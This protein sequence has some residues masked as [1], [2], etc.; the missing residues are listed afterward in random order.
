ME[1]CWLTCPSPR[2][3]SRQNI[4]I[5]DCCLG[6]FWNPDALRSS[7]LR[8][9]R[10]YLWRIF[11]YENVRVDDLTH[12]LSIYWVWRLH[13]SLAQSRIS[14]KFSSE[15]W[16]WLQ[17]KLHMCLKTTGLKFCFRRKPYGYDLKFYQ[18]DGSV[19]RLPPCLIW[20]WAMTSTPS[21]STTSEGPSASPGSVQGG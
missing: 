5:R 15:W 20:P 17:I 4:C 13:V 2:S 14:A 7:V 11:R 19:C 21:T 3:N 8:S 9:L 6:K 16:L 1:A 12:N 10:L 18:R